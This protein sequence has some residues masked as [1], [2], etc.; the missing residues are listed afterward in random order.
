MKG[1]YE[2]DELR[3]VKAE[4]GNQVTYRIEEKYKSFFTKKEKWRELMFP[5]RMTGMPISKT[6]YEIE[7]ARSVRNNLLKETT[8]VVD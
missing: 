3:I 6:F 4:R 5:C 8:E 7:K 1:H 2:E